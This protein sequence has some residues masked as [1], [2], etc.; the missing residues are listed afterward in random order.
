MNILLL[1]GGGR[2]HALAWKLRQSPLVKSLV[3]APG[4][5]GIAALGECVPLDITNAAAVVTLAKERSAHLVV[6]GPEAPLVAG[7]ADALRAAGFDVFGPDAAGARIEGSKAFAKE[8]MQAANV[9]TARFELFS[10]IEAAAARA[11][12]WGPVVVKADGL[13]AGKGVVVATSGQEAAEA[14]RALGALPSGQTILLEEVLTGPELSVMALCDGERFA[15]LAPS[16]D[17]KRVFDG[18]RGPN[19]G[20]M[21]AYAPANFLN[22]E[23]LD[24]VGRTVIAPTLAELRRRGISFRGTLYAG[25]MLTPA[26]HRVLEFNARLGDPETQVL[27]MQLDTDLVPVLQACARGA[28]TNTTLPQRAG[29]SVGIVLAAEGYPEAP[30][31]GDAIELPT[32]QPAGTQLFHAGTKLSGDQLVSAGG[33]V[34]TACASGATLLEARARATA[35]ADMVT[36]R[37]R[38]F[39]KD[40]A[41]GAPP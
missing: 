38:H 9:P 13:A 17:H 34:I 33:R 25:L 6:V 27:M 32:S 5:P 26:G 40:I 10:D 14:C 18:D 7:V 4:N 19:T 36:W 12:A 39:R 16:Q 20:G 2:E 28:L 41:A 22:P 35:L 29:F 11:L 23:Q 15:L 30:R 24:E 21:G 8:I 31:T 37:G 3:V 1:G